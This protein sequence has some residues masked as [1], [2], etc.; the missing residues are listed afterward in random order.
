V[1]LQS[2]STT[3]PCRSEV[4]E[5]EEKEESAIQRICS[6]RRDTLFPIPTIIYGQ[7]LVGTLIMSVTALVGVGLEPALIACS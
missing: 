2:F 7:P 5:C 1:W 4:E 6:T 3:L